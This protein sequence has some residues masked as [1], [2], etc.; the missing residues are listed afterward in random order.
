[1]IKVLLKAKIPWKNIEINETRIYEEGSTIEKILSD[2][3]IEMEDESNF[4]VAVNGKIEYKD[5][6]LQDDDTISILPALIGG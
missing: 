1:M 5:Y 4:L 2:I 3:G 6:V